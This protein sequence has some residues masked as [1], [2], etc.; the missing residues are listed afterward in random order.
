MMKWGRRRV[1]QWNGGKIRGDGNAKLGT[2]MGHE[3]GNW[4]PRIGMWE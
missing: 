4:K 1:E 2:W 3:T